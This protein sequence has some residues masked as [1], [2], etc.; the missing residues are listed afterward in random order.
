[1]DTCLGCYKQIFVSGHETTYD[2]TLVGKT[3]VPYRRLMEHWNRVLPGRVV[4]VV[5]EKLVADPETEIRRLLDRL[6]P[7]LGRC[8]PA[9]P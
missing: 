1:M 2:L 8:L 4:D 6:R 7:A 3:Y 9:I 5:Y